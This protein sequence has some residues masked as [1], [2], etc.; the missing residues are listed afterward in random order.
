MAG[1]ADPTIQEVKEAV[2]ALQAMVESKNGI[3]QEVLEKINTTL[4]AHETNNQ[5]LI[6]QLKSSEDRETEFKERM[7]VLETELA[8][9]GNSGKKDNYKEQPEYKALN[10]MAKIGVEVLSQ[11]HKASLRTDNDT[12]GGY[13]VPVEMDNLITKKIIE[14]SGI[15]AI[16]RV[17]T[18]GSKSLEMPI[19]N[20]IP[21]AT[22]EGEA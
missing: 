13:L 16:A 10:E 11:E 21:T 22:Y 8:R 6:T 12:S 2:G 15:R 3:D 17:R 14:I 18:I 9:A 4:D 1:E 7:D 19:R 20:T 5:E